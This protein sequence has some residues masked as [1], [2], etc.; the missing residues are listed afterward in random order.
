MA[1]HLKKHGEKAHQDGYKKFDP[2]KNPITIANCHNMVKQYN[3]QQ[4]TRINVFQGHLDT[5]KTNATLLK[6][7]N[8]NVTKWK[9]AYASADKGREYWAKSAK[10]ARNER[11]SI[12]ETSQFMERLS[13]ILAKKLCTQWEAKWH[14]F[15]DDNMSDANLKIDQLETEKTDLEWECHL[16]E[17]KAED[18]TERIMSEKKYRSL[19]IMCAKHEGKIMENTL[20]KY[21][22][23]MRA[24]VN[25]AC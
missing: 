21:R 10:K 1:A 20:T 14:N 6:D 23:R 24:L 9:S 15:E 22:E 19:M 5:I 3:R 2:S 7:A 12:T 11:E 8:D 13:G 25:L 17:G 16:A 4:R 18:L